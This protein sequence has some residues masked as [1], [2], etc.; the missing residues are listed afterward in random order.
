MARGGAG[1]TPSLGLGETA[2]AAAPAAAALV[3]GAGAGECPR[4]RRAAGQAQTSVRCRHRDSTRVSTRLSSVS[5]QPFGADQ[6]CRQGARWSRSSWRLPD[7]RRCRYGPPQ[8]GLSSNTMALI[9]SDCGAMRLPEHQIAIIA[10]G[11]VLQTTARAVRSRGGRARRSGISRRRC[12]CVSRG[13]GTHCLRW[14]FQPQHA[15]QPGLRF[16]SL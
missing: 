4:P 15:E 10:S 2:L 6:Q 14:P 1:N 8:H 5:V 9:T 3:L 13:G 12:R 11:C 16:C 7:G